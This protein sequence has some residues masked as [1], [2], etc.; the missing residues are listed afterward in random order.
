L[1][2]LLDLFSIVFRRSRFFLVGFLPIRIV[3]DFFGGRRI[4]AAIAT[5]TATATATAAAVVASYLDTDAPLAPQKSLDV[6]QPV[7]KFVSVGDGKPVH[8]QQLVSDL[9]GKP[10]LLEQSPQLGHHIHFLATTTT[11][12][13]TTTV[14]VA[15]AAAFV[16]FYQPQ[17]D[18]LAGSGPCN[19]G[20]DNVVEA[21]F[22]DLSA[23]REMSGPYP[24]SF[25][26]TIVHA[27]KEREEDDDEIKIRSSLCLARCHM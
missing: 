13:I 1:I 26:I 24:L 5:A 22:V 3:R 2:A 20:F 12:T 14:A 10:V 21:V 18:L 15:V 17:T 4:T 25:A 16:H 19:G 23:H 6:F 8:V 27:S 7:G 11:T 9:H